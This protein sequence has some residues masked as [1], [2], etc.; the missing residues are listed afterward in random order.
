MGA[1]F[2]LAAVAF[3]AGSAVFYNAHQ[4]IYY[5]HSWAVGVCNT[6]PLF[7]GQSEYLAYAAGACLTVGLGVL[8]GRA[9]SG[10]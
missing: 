2:I 3:G 5:G 1:L 9:M 10:E 6:S 8:V 4:Q 7:C